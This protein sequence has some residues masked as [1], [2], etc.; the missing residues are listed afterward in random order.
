MLLSKLSLETDR[1][2]IRPAEKADLKSV[3]SI[4]TDDEVN[5]YLPYD[6]W[7]A[8][9]D[10]VKW[11]D[12]VQ[13]RRA[14]KDAEQFVVVRKSDQKV[15]GTCIA[16]DFDES[17][18]SCEFGYVL[19]RRYWNNGYMLEAT[20]ALLEALLS[21]AEISSIRAVVQAPN[22]SS[23]KL[24]EKLGFEVIYAEVVDNKI[25]E[26]RRVEYLRLGSA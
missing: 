8:W 1:L 2:L 3:Y 4:H 22:T 12:R 18:Q 5:R 14:E 25:G 24:L 21:Q 20:R 10:A 6:T 13:Q 23:L 9:D 26:G 11:Y 17:D 16:F 19:N 15:V 7:T